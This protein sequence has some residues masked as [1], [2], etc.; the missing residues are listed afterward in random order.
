[1]VRFARSR[2]ARRACPVQRTVWLRVDG[3]PTFL[4]ELT[5]QRRGVSS[6]HPAGE[7]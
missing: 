6:H 3:R 7:E 1:M 2:E 5:L 4:M